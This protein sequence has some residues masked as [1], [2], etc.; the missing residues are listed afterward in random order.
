MSYR[1]QSRSSGN[2]HG[3][4][5]TVQDVL[6]SGTR[7]GAMPVQRFSSSN[8]PDGMGKVCRRFQSTVKRTHESQKLPTS[9]AAVQLKVQLSGRALTSRRV[10]WLERY[11]S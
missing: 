9:T 3:T 7:R 2:N 1:G 5:R 8:V 6:V 11:G 4:S 10:V